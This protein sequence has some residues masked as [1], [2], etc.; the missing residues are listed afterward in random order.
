MIKIESQLPRWEKGMI[1][2]GPERVW[3]GIP[4]PFF[5]RS[6][7]RY[8]PLKAPEKLEPW[9]EQEWRPAQAA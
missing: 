4:L 7:C 9:V 3:V 2:S 5:G 6:K 1:T 8:A